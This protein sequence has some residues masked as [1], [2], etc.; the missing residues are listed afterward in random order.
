MNLDIQYRFHKNTSY[1][2][3]LILSNQ[4]HIYTYNRVSRRGYRLKTSS[5]RI[6]HIPNILP[7]LSQ[8]HIVS[9]YPFWDIESRR[10]KSKDIL[11]KV[12][13][14]HYLHVRR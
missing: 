10:Q 13:C 11:E 5:L 7:F 14:L 9:Q 3:V 12:Y 1:D 8:G 2:C 4:P 6:S